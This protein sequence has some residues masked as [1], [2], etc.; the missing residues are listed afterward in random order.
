[1]ES[2]PGR[3]D[4]H[5]ATRSYP[6]GMEHPLVIDPADPLVE[7]VREICLSYPEAAEK[8]S[9]G[10]PTFRAG[11][12]VFVWMSSSMNRPYSFVFKPEPHA[13]LAHLEDSRFFVPPYWGSSGWLAI[14][15]DPPDADWAEFA[16]LIDA[17]YREVALMRQLRV[18][19][20]RTSDA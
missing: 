6:V 12:K 8:Q 4:A 17:S 1:V 7:R 10:R 15:I 5:H 14:D 20:A 2:A 16:E 18:L 9:F 13:R 11:K 19:D 3:G